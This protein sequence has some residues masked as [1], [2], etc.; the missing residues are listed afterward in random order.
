MKDILDELHN[1]LCNEVDDTTERLI[2][3]VRALAL[4]V[5]E[6]ENRTKI[7]IRSRDIPRDDRSYE[8]FLND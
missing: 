6:L 3:I 2:S 7:I 5:E 8:D 4:R 1:L